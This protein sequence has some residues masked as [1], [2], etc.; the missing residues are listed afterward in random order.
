MGVTAGNCDVGYGDWR[1]CGRADKLTDTW[2][3]VGFDLSITEKSF[4]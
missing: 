4:I 1:D 2:V 3:G